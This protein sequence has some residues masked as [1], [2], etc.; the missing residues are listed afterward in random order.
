MG[1]EE[2]VSEPATVPACAG[3]RAVVFDF[4]LTLADSS[5]SILRCFAHGCRAVGQP[6]PER[7]RALIGMPLVEMWHTLATDPRTSVR[8]AFVAAYRARAATHMADETRLFPSTVP[9]L[10]TLHARGLALAV[11]STKI[12]ERF[13][14]VLGR[15]Q[16]A[17]L[18][19]CMVGGESV[20]RHKPDPMGLLGAL[21]TLGVAP[22][23]ALYVGD[24][25]IDAETAQRAGAGFVA[26]TTGTTPRQA[27]D[28]YPCRAV[29]DDLSALSRILAFDAPS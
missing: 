6:E 21:E 1:R 2:A 14:D 9:T 16:V 7:V 25:T 24:S 29:L 28:A 23:A 27:F 11:V 22:D 13:E 8:D 18:F 15:A 19:G 5:T 3:V 26:V 12:R 17:P 4:D 10:R 20:P